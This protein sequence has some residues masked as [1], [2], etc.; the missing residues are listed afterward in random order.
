MGRHSPQTRVF[1]W[2]TTFSAFACTVV[3]SSSLLTTI[4]SLC[5]LSLCK[6]GVLDLLALCDKCSAHGRRVVGKSA[7]KADRARAS[8]AD[9]VSQSSKLR[10]RCCDGSLVT[11]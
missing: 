11:T 9:N 5:T 8:A 2:D 6:L 10:A 3:A 4:M 1:D 7:G